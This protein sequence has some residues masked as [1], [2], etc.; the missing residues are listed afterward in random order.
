M[1]IVVIG[2]TGRIGSKVVRGLTERGHDAVA[3]APSTGVDAFT[4]E[5]LAEALSGA[6]VVVDVTNSPS[7]DEEPAREFFTVATTNLLDAEARAGVA[8]HVA[9]SVVGTE[10][11]ARESGYFAAK[12]LQENLIAGGPVPYTIVR[13][14]Q[15]FEFLSAIADSATENGT[16]RLPGAL[17]QPMASADVAEAV[18]IAAVNAPVGGITEVGGPERFRMPDL[19]RTVLTARGDRRPVVADPHARYWGAAI[20]D[21]TLVPGD[22][23]ALFDHRLEDWVL[24]TAARQ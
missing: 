11:L 24:E 1:R 23:A 19:I 21:H 18:A 14:T 5:G 2:G 9:L 16:V 8:H 15:F 6:E 12:L 17:I 10:Q 3:A 7:F 4:G 20:D 22:G 13:A